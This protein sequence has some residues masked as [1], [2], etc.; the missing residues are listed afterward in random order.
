MK[1]SNNRNKRARNEEGLPQ[2][3][4]LQGGRKSLSIKFCSLQGEGG[5]GFS[6]PQFYERKKKTAQGVLPLA[7][8]MAAAG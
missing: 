2:K 5:Q 6:P 8:L 1:E 7:V 4:I 3:I